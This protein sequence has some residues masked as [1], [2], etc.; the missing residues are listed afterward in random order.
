M[1]VIV[2]LNE[3]EIDG[4]T[5]ILIVMNILSDSFNQFN[6]DYEL[7]P[8]QYTLTSLMKD[9]KITEGILKKKGSLLKLMYLKKI[10]RR[11]NPRARPRRTKNQRP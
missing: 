11:P 4:D 9:L 3:A 7:H 6:V 10:L 8:K 5:Q 2:C 1:K